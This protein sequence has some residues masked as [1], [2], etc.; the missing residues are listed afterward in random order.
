MGER[1]SK[2]EFLSLEI[3]N[4]NKVNLEFLLHV[5]PLTPDF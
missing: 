1:V 5:F 4:E 3:A 2:L